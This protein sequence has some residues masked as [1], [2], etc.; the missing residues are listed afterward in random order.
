MITVNMRYIALV[1]S[2]ACPSN[3]IHCADEE[4]VDVETVD[5]AEAGAAPT[6]SDKV[7]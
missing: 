5:E 2:H 1:G 3:P 6:G 4:F 7:C